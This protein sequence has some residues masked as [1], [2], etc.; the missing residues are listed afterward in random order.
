MVAAHSGGVYLICE[1]QVGFQIGSDSILHQEGLAN[2][3]DVAV[4]MRRQ[5]VTV[6]NRG[7]TRLILIP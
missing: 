1:D 6:D 7:T 4:N 3:G 2:N 5:E